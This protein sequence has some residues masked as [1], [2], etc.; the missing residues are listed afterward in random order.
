M[1]NQIKKIGITLR[2]EK[3]MKFNEKRDAISHDWVNFLENQNILPIFIPNTL[4]DTKNYLEEMKLD[5]LI[6]SG[7]DNKG[8]DIDRDNTENEIIEFVMERQIPLLGIC[9]GMQVINNFFGGNQKTTT[10]LKHIKK[11][12]K[13]NIIK[14]KFQNYLQKNEIEV[15]SFH[16]NII[17]KNTVG[18]NLEVFALAEIDNTVEGFYHK[19]FPILG[20][21]WHPERENIILDELKLMKIFYEKIFWAK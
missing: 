20:I 8:D 1:T 13:I 14:N 3:I 15:N 9:R 11:H 17:Q 19:E 12:H 16:N 5:G 21:M 10:N 18:K 2:V 7:G 6:M 4:K